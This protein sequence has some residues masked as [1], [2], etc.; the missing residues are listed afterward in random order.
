MVHY[1]PALPDTFAALGDPTRLAMLERLV[2]GEA[3]VS[4]LARPHEMSLPGI[5]K[6][7]R[8]LERAGLIER[9]KHGRIRR[10]RLLP[11]PMQDAA[12]WIERHRVF[13]EQQL[14]ALADF[15]SENEGNEENES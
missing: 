11:R 14:D 6:H 5:S 12:A 1:S 7:L 15:L 8:V 13:W 10:C 4:E 9:K 3:T 2:H